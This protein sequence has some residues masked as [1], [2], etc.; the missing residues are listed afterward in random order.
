MV[1]VVQVHLAHCTLKLLYIVWKAHH[2]WIT[3]RNLVELRAAPVNIVFDGLFKEHAILVSD[4]ILPVQDLG[5]GWKDVSKRCVVTCNS[6][7][8]AQKPKLS[9]QFA[10]GEHL[11]FAKCIRCAVQ[12]GKVHS[13]ITEFWYKQFWKDLPKQPRIDEH[14]ISEYMLFISSLSSPFQ[15]HPPDTHLLCLYWI[16]PRNLWL[17]LSLAVCLLIQMALTTGNFRG[18]SV[19]FSVPFVFGIRSGCQATSVFQCR[20][21]VDDLLLALH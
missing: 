14:S 17:M 21:G 12:T 16:H 6:H 8:K 3:D 4:G 13:G 19:P 5:T 7:Q 1:C 10:R 2:V 9:Q 15:F 18:S 20:C 11:S